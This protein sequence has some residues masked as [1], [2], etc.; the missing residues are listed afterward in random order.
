[1]SNSIVFHTIYGHIESM[2]SKYCPISEQKYNKKIVG[3]NTCKEGQYALV[4]RKNERF[5]IRMDDNCYL[6]LYHNK[7]L[8]IDTISN[9]NI[10]Y[11]L[12]SFTIEDAKTTSSILEDYFNNILDNKKS[13]FRTNRNY[14]NGYFLE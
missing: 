8:Y 10:D 2:I 9:L 6:H 7:P 3:C 1:H 13:L 5:P 14:T 4:D 11:A 12:L